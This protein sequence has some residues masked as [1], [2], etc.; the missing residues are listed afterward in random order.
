[1]KPSGRREESL[2]RQPVRFAV[3]GLAVVILL[4]SSCGYQL[5]GRG[6]TFPEGVEKVAVKPFKNQTDRSRLEG[7][8]S[9][10]FV[11][12]LITIGKVT[13]VDIKDA[14]AWFEGVLRR[15]DK[16]PI[17]YGA[18]QEILERRVVITA[19][20]T[21]QVKGEEEPFYYE[22]TV[23]GKA[24]YRVTDDLALDDQSEREAALEALADL[25][26][27]VISEITEGF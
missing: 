20:V 24:E 7:E 3:S 16:A 5:V 18:D 26:S 9:D 23:R 4:L 2:I 14:D 25:A 17:S 15:Y 11:K 12:E 13:I 27:R 19:E 10:I 22:E 6:G 8:A 21:F 1:M